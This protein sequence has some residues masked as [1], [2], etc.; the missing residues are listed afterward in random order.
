MNEIVIY[1]RSHNVPLNWLDND[2]Q[3]QNTKQ[4]SI[5]T[6]DLLRVIKSSHQLN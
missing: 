1:A 2:Q 3:Q 4:N 5:Q 6:R